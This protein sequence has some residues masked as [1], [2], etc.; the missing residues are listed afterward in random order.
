MNP[1]IIL[2][3]YSYPGVNS[4][5]NLTIKD[6]FKKVF[7]I[8]LKKMPVIWLLS[9]RYCSVSPIFHFTSRFIPRF[10]F[11]SLLLHYIF[12]VLDP[13]SMA[14][15]FTIMCLAVCWRTDHFLTQNSFTCSA[16]WHN[17]QPKRIWKDITWGIL[18]RME[19]AYFD[20]SERRTKRFQ[21][22]LCLYS[23]GCWS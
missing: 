3:W 1:F 16:W 4:D 9:H 21:I 15:I 2:F 13:I 11:T 8:L 7:S 10:F 12:C 5:D 20:L 18:E 23:T 22:L 6:N 19:S 14:S 17:T